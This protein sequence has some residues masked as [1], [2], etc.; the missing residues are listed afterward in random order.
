MD[1]FFGDDFF[2]DLLGEFAST[3]IS[4]IF[5]NNVQKA[6]DKITVA[7]LQAQLKLAKVG[8]AVTAKD[9]ARENAIN[10]ANYNIQGR[11]NLR[12]AQ[13][14]LRAYNAETV[15]SLRRIGVGSSQ[16]AGVVAQAGQ[17]RLNENIK[18]AIQDTEYLIALANASTKDA[19]K[20][21]G[22][23]AKST[24]TI[25]EALIGDVQ[26][27]QKSARNNQFIGSILGDTLESLSEG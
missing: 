6:N 10:V 12:E 4:G 9:L 16:T 22:D 24:D 23:A 25:N 13:D 2:S 20:T 27:A 26:K 7:N 8:Y 18:D 14:E 3:A 11:N 5:N 19:I 15:A 17:R 1:E 21:Y